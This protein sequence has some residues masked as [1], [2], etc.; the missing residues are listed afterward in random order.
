M[1]I[2]PPTDFTDRVAIVTGAA[3]GLGHAAVARLLERGARVAVNVRDRGRAEAVAESFGAGDRV[4]AVPG[5]V[6]A[7][8][9]PE[10]I[11][12]QTLAR[13]GR[14][15]IL[16]NNAAY[17]RPARFASLTAS[18]WRQALEV[19]LTAP[20]LFIQA[21]LPPMKAQ[22][23][24]R[25]VNISSTA[26]RTVSTLGGAHYTASKAGLLGLTRA[27]AKELGAFG[28]TVNAI[29]PGMIDTELTRETASQ[30]LL[31]RLAAGFP[32]PRLGTAG[33]V[34]DLICFIASEAAGYMTGTSLDISGGDLMM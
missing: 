24:G 2:A 19:N 15:D 31:D 7:D 34:A 25:I 4:L 17:A 16:V 8:G 33:E 18:E 21:V 26:G 11:V 22:Q 5:D 1:S 28:I 20:F 27:A 32:V 3:R 29:C 14:V 6:A 30:E 12:Q 10:S 9:A 13:F 23:Y